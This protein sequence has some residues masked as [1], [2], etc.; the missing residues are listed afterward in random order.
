M[1]LLKTRFLAVYSFRCMICKKV[2]IC[3][4]FRNFW[5]SSKLFISSKSS[6]NF[7]TKMC[8]FWSKKF[9]LPLSKRLRLQDP[10]NSEESLEQILEQIPGGRSRTKVD[11][12]WSAPVG[13]GWS[14]A[15]KQ[16]CPK[17]DLWV[18]CHVA[19]ISREE[20]YLNLFGKILCAGL[21]KR[22][23]RILVLFALTI[24]II[25]RSKLWGKFFVVSS[26]KKFV[27][28]TADRIVKKRLF[29]ITIIVEF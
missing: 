7:A 25:L 23:T 12:G 10:H 8:V 22:R 27:L 4:F 3:D 28:S 15:Y 2:K 11:G 29:L 24:L 13:N 18:F 17:A 1:I 16:T 5:K 21:Q 14:E 26:G 9:C 6:R 19:S 20:E